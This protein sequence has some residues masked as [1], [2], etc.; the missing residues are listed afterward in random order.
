[1]HGF[2]AAIFAGLL[3]SLLYSAIA[4]LVVFSIWM[5]RSRYHRQIWREA[6]KRKTQCLVVLSSRVV[7]ADGPGETPRCSASEVRALARIIVLLRQFR[8]NAYFRLS[9]DVSDD[10]L[11]GHNIILLGSQKENIITRRALNT[12]NLAGLSFDPVSR[13]IKI[14]D[15]IYKPELS[16]STNLPIRDYALIVRS[17][18]PFRH[19]Q[20]RPRRSLIMFM[21][22]YGIGTDGAVQAAIDRTALAVLARRSSQRDF[23][24]VVR[25]EIDGFLVTNTAVEFVIGYS[26]DVTS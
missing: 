24:A 14:R 2:I 15:R 17:P 25:V 1:M 9:N 26:I 5:V 11:S 22:C 13:E 6:L 19:Q 20:G 7:R 8:V 23:V 21:G 18:N 3:A 4:A 16:P 10:E 12:L